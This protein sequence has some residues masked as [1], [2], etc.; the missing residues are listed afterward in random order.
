MQMGRMYQDK[1]RDKKKFFFYSDDT[2]YRQ[3]GKST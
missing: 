1:K 3:I 2:F